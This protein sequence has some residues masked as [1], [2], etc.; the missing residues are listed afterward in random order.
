ML[1]LSPDKDLFAFKHYQLIKS[2]LSSF[3][4]EVKAN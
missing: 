3:S 2:V 1:L 4:L